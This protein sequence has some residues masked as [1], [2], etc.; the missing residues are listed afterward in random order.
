MPTIDERIMKKFRD[1]LKDDPS[2][3]AD[4]AAEV[5]SRLELSKLPKADEL[6]ALII[7]NSGDTLA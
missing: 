6:A 1:G 4:L 7:G 5:A 2:V 3:T